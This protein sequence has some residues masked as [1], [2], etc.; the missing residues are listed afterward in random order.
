MFIPT[1]V[2]FEKTLKLVPSWYVEMDI[3]KTFQISINWKCSCL[4]WLFGIPNSSLYHHHHVSLERKLQRVVTGR[5]YND[6]LQGLLHPSEHPLS[7]DAKSGENLD[8]TL[9]LSC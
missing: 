2:Q 4:K 1:S 6:L 5:V 7:E 9:K 3:P 8:Q